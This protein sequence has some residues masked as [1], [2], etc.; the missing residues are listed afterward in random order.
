MFKESSHLI[1][2]NI[3]R[4]YQRIAEKVLCQ[5]RTDNEINR[6]QLYFWFNVGY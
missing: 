3:F 6:G 1:I 2:Q 5:L 4:R